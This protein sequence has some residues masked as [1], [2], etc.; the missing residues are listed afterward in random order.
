M[1]Y[2][3]GLTN[4]FSALMQ[5]RFETIKEAEP[6]AESRVRVVRFRNNAPVRKKEVNKNAAVASTV[7]IQE[8]IV[9]KAVEITKW[10]SR[11][12]RF[13]KENPQERDIAR[14]KRTEAVSFKKIK[15]AAKKNVRRMK[16]SS[17]S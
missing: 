9:R 5:N 3:L 11:N 14:T 2:D 7:P 1:D 6:I 10:K 16:A 15:L 8:A 4:R 13:K 12:Q 17:S